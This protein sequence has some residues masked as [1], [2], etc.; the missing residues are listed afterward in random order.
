M[1]KAIFYLLEEDHK[2]NVAGTSSGKSLAFA[3]PILEVPLVVLYLGLF[4][5]NRVS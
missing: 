2:P 1:P 3:L 4:R 5:D